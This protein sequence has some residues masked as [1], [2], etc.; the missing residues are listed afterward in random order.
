MPGPVERW[1]GHEHLRL[2]R[3]FVAIDREILLTWGRHI[4]V[5]AA[6]TS[7]VTGLLW[8]STTYVPLLPSSVAFMVSLVAVT[9]VIYVLARMLHIAANNSAQ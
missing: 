6:L 1:A 2:W 9:T 3:L 5:V 4:G 7:G 8:V